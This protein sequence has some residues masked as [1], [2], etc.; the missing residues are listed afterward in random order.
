MAAMPAYAQAL[1][2]P[3]FNLAWSNGRLL[4]A[5]NEPQNWL[6]PNQ[7]VQSHRFSRLTEI[8]RDNVGELELVWAMSLGGAPDVSGNNGANIMASPMVDNG[9]MYAVSSWQRI[10]KIDLRNPDQGDLIWVS[11]PQIE[12]EGQSSQTRGIA[13]YGQYIYN[14]LA[15]GRFVAH[16]LET[17]EIVGDV[18]MA[19]ATPYGGTEE[20]NAAP[21]VH[22]GP[23]RREKRRWGCRHAGLDRRSRSTVRRTVV[24]DLRHSGAG[25]ARRGNLAGSEPDGLD[26]RGRG[27]WTI[28]SY[29][30]SPL[31]HLGH[32]QP[33]SDL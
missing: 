22:Q 4:N 29:I 14:P 18:Q 26:P 23:V 5:D 7:N 1:P 33:G 19:V 30:L 11:D 13:L 32:R 12:H 21:A 6:L 3:N 16:D 31:P 8:N 9:I 27:M 20:F 24:A 15:D 17:G 28:G 10:F 2:Q 25:P